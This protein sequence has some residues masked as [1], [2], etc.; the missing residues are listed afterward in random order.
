MKII[1]ANHPDFKNETSA[2][3]KFLTSKGHITIFL[4]KFHCELNGIERVWG[5]S[6]RI[7]RAHCD[8]SIVS[9]R[10][11]VPF[12]LDSITVDTIKAYIQRSRHH[13]YLYLGGKKPGSEMEKAVKKLGKA[14][15]SHRRVG[16]NE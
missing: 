7:V 2:L 3:E 13:M 14:Y 12:G 11:T 10:E 6:K 4:P 9:L 16:V 8:Y 5:H 15:K 1:L